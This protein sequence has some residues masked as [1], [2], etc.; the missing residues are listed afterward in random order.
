MSVYCYDV[1]PRT[2]DNL[3]K[4]KKVMDRH[5][6][7]SQTNQYGDYYHIEVSG[8][9]TAHISRILKRY[10]YKYRKYEKRWERSGN[11]RKEFFTHNHGPYHCAYC[12]KHLK[13]SDIEVDH[14]IPVG[15][16]KKSFW[17]RV[18]LF[19]CGIYNVNNYRN[20]VSACHKCNQKKSDKMGFW[21][22]RG[23][24]GRSNWFWPLWRL[25]KVALVLFIIYMVLSYLGILPKFW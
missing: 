12:G 2:K 10:N 25:C 14:L 19:F 4:M 8:W 5:G 23:R 7:M 18:L 6:F 9:D 16:T 1:Y 22:I 11:Y 15:Q 17:A 20:L 13:G 3:L 21:V 24:L